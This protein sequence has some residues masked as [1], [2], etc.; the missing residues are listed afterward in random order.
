VETQ[1]GKKPQGGENF[2]IILKLQE[3]QKIYW[4]ISELGSIGREL[5]SSLEEVCLC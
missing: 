5:P 3:L 1:I 2:T 4:Y